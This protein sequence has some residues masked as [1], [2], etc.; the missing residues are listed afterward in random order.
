MRSRTLND[1]RRTLQVRYLLTHPFCGAH[2]HFQFKVAIAVPLSNSIDVFANDVG[3]IVIA[4]VGEK[5]GLIKFNAT[6]G[7][8]MGVTY[9]SKK[10]YP[11]T[12]D[13]PGFCAA[14]QGID[15]A[16]KVR[17]VQRHNGNRTEYVPDVNSL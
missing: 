2:T 1:D 4:T 16:E 17:F 9:G 3:F 15:V 8:G 7:G 5:G 11:R 10:M 13:V 6:A 14:E 12:A